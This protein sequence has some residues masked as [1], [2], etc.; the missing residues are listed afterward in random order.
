[1]EP[2]AVDASRRR[3]HRFHANGDGDH[4]WKWARAEQAFLEKPE[5]TKPLGLFKEPG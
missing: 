5:G 3:V 1:M 2:S 4:Y